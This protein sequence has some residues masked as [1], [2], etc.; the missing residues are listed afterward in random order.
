M[1]VQ[2]QTLKNGLRLITAPMPVESVTVM[3]IIGAG[4]RYET[5]RIKGISHFSEHM[6][7]K[8][9]LKRPSAVTI[10]S[11]IDAIGG[12]FNAATS[13]EETVFY[14][15]SASKHL[16]LVM[17]VLADIVLNP[18][19]DRV[20]IEKEKGVVIEE[21]NMYEDTP[22]FKIGDYFERLLY[23]KSSLGWDVV[24]EE[25][26]IQ[27]L[28]REDFVQYR[29]RL[30][31]PEN[32]L[33]VVAG[34]FKSKEVKR[35]AENYLGDF[36]TQGSKPL[37]QETFRQ[38]EPQVFLR[39]KKTD[40]AH[41]ILGVR[42]NPLGHPDRYAEMVLATLLGGGMSSRLF[43]EVR[44]KR[45]LAYYI[46]TEVSHYLD[47][48][49]LATIAGVDTKRI[50]Q[51]VKVIL[52]EYQK[53]VK[54]NKISQKELQKAKEF[55][56]GRLIL[57]LED[58]RAVANLFGVQEFFERQLRTPAEIMAKI[59]QV[60]VQ[61]LVRVARQFF[62]NDRLNLALIGPEQNEANLKKILRFN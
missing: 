42:G 21:L 5:A 6:A 51:A 20:E 39:T 36:K 48:G 55:I 35:L 1:E 38:T 12:Y 28:T 9:T 37:T 57:E 26:T 8:G 15:K 58:S 23:P 50:A 52:G 3:M 61:D 27:A 59:D 30:Y 41:L 49:Y 4:S 18:K 45:G 11:L 34:G 24:G 14:A 7:F 32:M 2:K 17:D 33:L 46:R 47:N 62:T 54:G 25:K 19:L 44:E 31:F 29:Q 40:Q 10:S 13:K 56:K 16:P 43:I 22:I 60:S 53:I